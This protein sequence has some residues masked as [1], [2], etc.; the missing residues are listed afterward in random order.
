MCGGDEVGLTRFL[1]PEAGVAQNLFTFQKF[2]VMTMYFMI[3]NFAKAE[4]Q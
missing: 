1:F 3:D 2:H 4:C